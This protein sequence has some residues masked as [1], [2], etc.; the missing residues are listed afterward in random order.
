MAVGRISLTAELEGLDTLLANLG[1]ALD[2]N[3][4]SRV[5]EK[6]LK[7]AVV[8]IKAALERTTPLGPTGNLRN[9]IDVKV[10]RY[11]LD[12]NAVGVVGFRRS[13]R[14]PSSVA[15]GGTVRVGPDRA[16]HQWWLEEGT[17]PRYVGTP[18]DKP[19]TRKAHQRRMK[20]GVVAD[21]REHE[22]ARQGGYIASSFN[23]LGPFKMQQTPRVP[24]GGKG[25]RVLTEPGYPR[26]FFK[27]SSTP[28]TIPAMSPGG[29]GPP[30][31]RTAFDQTQATVAEILSRELRISLEQIWGN[32]SMTA[33]PTG[34]IE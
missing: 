28:I 14:Q 33:S 19:Y 27:K 9:A 16:F 10:V 18:A 1:K 32:L 15:A 21:V 24:R 30:P 3:E 34:T 6:A 20:S 8:P 2:N 29:S 4:K 22:V 23:R 7:K 17:Q 12:G 11:P 5:L 26:A 13:G 31:L 25:Q